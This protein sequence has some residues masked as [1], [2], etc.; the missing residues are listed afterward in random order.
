MTRL[1]LM[2]GLVGLFCLAV[3][4]REVLRK[5]YVWAGLAFACVLLIVLMPIPTHA[6]KVDLGTATGPQD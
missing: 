5:D 6:E 2:L 3:G 1:L 4:I